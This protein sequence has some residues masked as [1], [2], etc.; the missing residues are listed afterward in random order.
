[1]AYIA[2]VGKYQKWYDVMTQDI[3]MHKTD[4][5]GTFKMAKCMIITYRDFF[6]E[7]P[8]WFTQ[9]LML[10]LPGNAS[11][12]IQTFFKDVEVMMGF[13]RRFLPTPPHP[14]EL[15]TVN[16][17]VLFDIARM[18][19][20]M[21]AVIEHVMNTVGLGSDV[22]TDAIIKLNIRMGIDGVVAAYAQKAYVEMEQ[23][24]SIVRNNMMVRMKE[25]VAA[26]KKKVETRYGFP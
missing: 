7:D 4:L 11:I 20:I 13:S 8:M 15:G 10:K 6:A 3:V 5:Y 2:K 21:D 19:R 22:T 16:R 24:I 12:D 26:F 17:P 14:I 18:D 23:C 25:D 9:A 1:M